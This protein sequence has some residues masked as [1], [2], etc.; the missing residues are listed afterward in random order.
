LRDIDS[1]W[2]V[3]AQHVPVLAGAVVEVRKLY[4]FLGVLKALLDEMVKM[5]SAATLDHV[6]SLA[7]REMMA[8]QGDLVKTDLQDLLGHQVIVELEVPM[9]LLG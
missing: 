6:G 5:D 9:V 2:R 7:S 1:R 3:I 4:I 8:Y